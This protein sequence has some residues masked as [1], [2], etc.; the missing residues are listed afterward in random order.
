MQNKGMGFKPTKLTLAAILLAS[1]V[2]IMGA[3]AVAP[4]LEPIKEAFGSSAFVTSLV[5]TL[6]ALAVA[7]TGF[8]VGF[9]AD[10]FGKA[11]VFIVSLGIF[12]VAGAAGYFAT[13]MAMMLAIRFILGIGIA[14]ISITATALI[15][16]YWTGINRMKIISYQSAMIGIGALVLE[17]LGG[18]LADIGWKEPFLIYLIGIPFMLI[19]LV[20]VRDMPVPKTATDS[21][22]EPIVKR[23]G[24]Q[25]F[26]YLCIFMGMFLMF[27][28]PLNFSYYAAEIGVNLGVIGT[29]LGVLG[30][31]QAAFSVLYSRTANKLKDDK[32]YAASFLMIA[33]GLGLLYIPE[34]YATAPSMILIGCGMGLLTPTVIGRL[35]MLSTKATSGK[36]MGGYTVSMNLGTFVSG[37]IITSLVAA[38]GDSYINAYATLAVVAIAMAGA[39]FIIGTPAVR[40]RK[41]VQEEVEVT[42]VSSV[43]I[44]PADV[45]MY[46]SILV[47]TDGS[48]NSRESVINA[49]N[50]AMKNH[51]PMTAIYVIDPERVSGIAG[52]TS[53]KNSGEEIAKEA[54]SFVTELA[55]EKGVTVTAKIAYGHAADEIIAESANHDLVVCGSLG[56]TNLSRAVMGSVA[57][58]VVRL[59]HCQVLV[60]RKNLEKTE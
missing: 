1:M 53:A 42:H 58:K 48:V 21:G 28:V 26:C 51:A 39:C 23:R 2:I 22:E 31:S 56:R 9:L 35:S 33:C 44:D 27:S 36:V 13:S 6:P 18:T 37:L 15:G 5:I 49:V 38:V 34:I 55:T 11:K 52:V 29:L 24:E 47:P 60:C 43:R 16:E 10:R 12:A 4:A 45:R 54:L 59:A 14:G 41:R 25:M 20:S 7:V 46:R 30:I 17:S 19:A 40:M 32:A 50:I 57:E 8:G 3:A